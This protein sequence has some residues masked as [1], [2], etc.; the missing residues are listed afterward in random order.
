MGLSYPNSADAEIA[1]QK[2]IIRE[3]DV[4]QIRNAEKAR[5]GPPWKTAMGGEIGIHGGGTRSN[6]TEG[7]IALENEAIEEIWLA[8][9]KGTR[10]EIKP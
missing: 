1:L 10:V 5:V 8:T 7:C 2:G 6:W 9:A 4:L 3:S